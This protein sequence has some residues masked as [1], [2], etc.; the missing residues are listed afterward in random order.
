M[1]PDGEITAE[2][3]IN[4]SAGERS[5]VVKARVFG[6]EA[7]DIE[8]ADQ[9]S[10]D[11]SS[12]LAEIG[13]VIAD[14]IEPPYD[15]AVLCKLYE[16]SSSLRQNVDAY[17]TNIDGFGHV[18][19]P[20]VQLKESGAS[21]QVRDALY[22]ERSQ[23]VQAGDPAA[24]AALVP[25]T[26]LEVS[27][28]IEELRFQMRIEEANVKSF[29]DN[30]VAEESFSSLRCKTREDIEVTGNGYWEVIRSD[31]GTVSQFAHMPSRSVRAVK[32]KG[33]AVP[34]SQL[35][36]VG[37]LG[38]RTETFKRRFRRYV[39]AG[40]DT[41]VWFKEFGDP[42]IVSSK[43]GKTYATVEELAGA[44]ANTE[45][46]GEVFHFK[47]HS[48]K[49]SAYGV[50]RWIG[51]LLSVLGSRS[52]EEV[53]LAYFDNK[54]IPPM[55]ILVSGGRLGEESVKRIEDFVETQLKGRRNFHKILVIEA[56]TT[57]GS[58]GIGDNSGTMKVEIKM[59]TDAQLKDGLFLAYDAANMD[60][61]GMGFRLPRL[62]RGDIRDF[63][64]ASA[65]AA[66][67]FAESQVFVPERNAF[68][69]AMNRFFLPNLGIRYWRF[70]SNGPRLSDAQSW[71]DMIVKLTNAGILT[72]ADARDL[73]SKKVLAHE[74]PIIEADWTKQPL[75]LTIAG[76]QADTT[77][78]GNIPFGG[79]AP[80]SGVAN[81]DQGFGVTP[82]PGLIKAAKDRVV[83]QAKALLKLRNEFLRQEAEQAVATY[84]AE[85]IEEGE[86]VFNMT[87]EQMVDTFGLASK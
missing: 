82:A 2:Q 57:A 50:P 51:N 28:K 46:A 65:E 31:A 54:S 14:A 61:V 45:P 74:L 13:M 43:T 32:S 63:N 38:F 69:F 33:G 71:G 85:R 62:L 70:K 27:A 84:Q 24:L 12:P 18:F 40:G 81:V 55:A 56:E 44:E 20:V 11:T 77:L 10:T 15:S 3:R 42:T 25:P 23:A 86:L 76:I 87:K 80:A 66:L 68:D 41:I 36:R 35:V 64:R 8:K 37:L 29:F 73:T 49:N 34:V 21:D 39:Q 22:L 75:G 17:K 79:A 16:H 72:P 48:L 53:N 7:V 19:E 78:D 5:I 67:D 6:G 4:R 83:R 9:Q 1:P 58:I 30:C 59:L 26:D 60:K 47:I 52:A